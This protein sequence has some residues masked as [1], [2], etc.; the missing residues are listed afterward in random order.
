M[1]LLDRS[2]V[3][4]LVRVIPDPCKDI[5]MN[6]LTLFHYPHRPRVMTCENM[7]EGAALVLA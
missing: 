1:E 7:N 5:G 4:T 3:G 6:I 2:G